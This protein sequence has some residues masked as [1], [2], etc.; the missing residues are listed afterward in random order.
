MSL[1]ERATQSKVEN[2]ECASNKMRPLHDW[3]S[4][5]NTIHVVIFL[6]QYDLLSKV[7]N[8]KYIN[9]KK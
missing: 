2:T 4:L 9:L 8:I 3:W 5:Q 1:V 7:K 6:H